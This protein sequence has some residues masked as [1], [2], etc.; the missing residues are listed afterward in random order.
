MCFK[1]QRTAANDHTVT[2]D[3][4]IFQIPKTS[5][6]RSYAHKRIDVGV[7]LDGA[8]EF[9]YK[10]EKIA[11]FDSKKTHA[12]GLYR[13]QK[14]REGFRYGPISNQSADYQQLSP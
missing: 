12:F 6:H 4:V 2:L 14:K 1:Q 9:F 7:L 5:P 8:V 11:A 10:T 3:G 13:T